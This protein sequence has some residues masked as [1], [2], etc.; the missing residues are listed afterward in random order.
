MV[1]SEVE[2]VAADGQWASSGMRAQD[3]KSQGL[4]AAVD[5]S[6]RERGSID[7]KAYLTG[8][9]IRRGGRMAR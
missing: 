3:R 1:D 5:L 8:E 7:G 2:L 6:V 9:D 4:A